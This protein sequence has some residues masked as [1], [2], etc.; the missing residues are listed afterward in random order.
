MKDTYG[1]IFLQE[2]AMEVF[3]TCAG[4]DEM[5][6]DELRRVISKSK[7][8]DVMNTYKSEFMIGCRNTGLIKKIHGWKKYGKRY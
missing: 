2:T 6:V 7:G 3:R 4:M 1:G 5:K 8:K